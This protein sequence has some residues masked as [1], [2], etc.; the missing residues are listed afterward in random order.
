MRDQTVEGLNRLPD[1]LRAIAASMAHA[2]LRTDLAEHNLPPEQAG[3]IATEHRAADTDDWN[4]AMSGAVAALLA[5]R[6]LGYT[7]SR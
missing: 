1:D 3:Q 2:M 7:L 5:L 6:D 4:R